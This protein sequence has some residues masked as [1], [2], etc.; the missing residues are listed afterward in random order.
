MFDKWY[1]D[2]KFPQGRPLWQN[3]ASYAPLQAGIFVGG[4][5][6]FVGS[7]VALNKIVADSGKVVRPPMHARLGM[8]F[9][10]A[11]GYGAVGAT[12][13]LV[14]SA[15]RIARD[16]QSEDFVS[17]FSGGAAAG[18]LMAARSTS[19]LGLRRTRY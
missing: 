14:Q 6:G 11:G 13:A 12:F 5:A 8:M 3:P 19:H 16:K 4:Y 10:Y 2:Y 1:P 7:L 18:F 17:S 15:V 9:R